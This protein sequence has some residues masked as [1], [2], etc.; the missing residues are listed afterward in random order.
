MSHG[1]LL[2]GYRSSVRRPCPTVICQATIIALRCYKPH[3]CTRKVLSAR[4]TE[5]VLLFSIS[6]CCANV[7]AS[8]ICKTHVSTLHDLIPAK[9]SDPKSVDEVQELERV[10]TV[11]HSHLRMVSFTEPSD[12]GSQAF[13]IVDSPS[14]DCQSAGVLEAKRGLQFATAGTFRGGL[15]TPTQRAVIEEAIVRFCSPAFISGL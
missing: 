9:T 5:G 15:I 1:P 12:L 13:A 7:R 3:R 8:A 6:V 2:R 11:K 14:T 10:A 4:S